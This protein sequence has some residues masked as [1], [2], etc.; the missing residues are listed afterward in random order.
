MKKIAFTGALLLAAPV[1][2][3]VDWEFDTALTASLIHTNNVALAPADNEQSDTIMLL[4]PVFSLTGESNRLDL[5]FRYNPQGVFYD[6]TDDAD[7][8]FHVLDG[9]L[10][11]EVMDDR[12]FVT[13]KADKFQT[14][15]T[16]EGEIPQDNDPAT[17]TRADSTV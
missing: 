14:I 4:S 5:D 6:N 13:F 11:G 12:L 15:V 9:S 8:V 17:K 7:Q 3:A 16:P 1:A 10:T 2:G